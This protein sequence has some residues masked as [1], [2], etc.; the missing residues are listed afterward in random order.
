VG[1]FYLRMGEG[2]S[3][4]REYREG[5]AKDLSKKALTRS[6]SSKCSF[7]EGKRAEAADLNSQI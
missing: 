5:M 7:A 1:D 2:D 4:I 3:A 6:A